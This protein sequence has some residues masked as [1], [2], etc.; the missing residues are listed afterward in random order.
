MVDLYGAHH[1]PSSLGKFSD[2][3]WGDFS[4]PYQ[5][6]YV[7]VST[8]SDQRRRLPLASGRLHRSARIVGFPAVGTSVVSRPDRPLTTSRLI[9]THI[10]PEHT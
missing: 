4:D 10:E 5:S 2:R 3:V 7:W 9:G 8:S 6:S 1:P